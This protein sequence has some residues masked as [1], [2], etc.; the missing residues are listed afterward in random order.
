MRR[1]AFAALAVGTAYLG[2]LASDIVVRAKAPALAAMPQTPEPSRA[3]ARWVYSTDSATA[4]AE[5]VD[6]IVVAR[7]SGTRAAGVARSANGRSGLE[8]D[9]DDFKIE[10]VIKGDLAAGMVTVQRARRSITGRRLLDHDGGLYQRGGRYLLFLKRQPNAE[11][12]Y[13]VNDQGR[14]AVGADGR[15]QSMADGGVA[16]SIRGTTVEQAA[17]NINRM[18]RNP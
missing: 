11:T 14:Y 3:Q 5:Y 6:A 16:A 10:R 4:L 18:L 12:F 7:H 9:N 13:L 2:V 15:L 8:F 1:L 17:A